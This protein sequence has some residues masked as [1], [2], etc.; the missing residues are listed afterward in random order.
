MNQIAIPQ[1]QPST[2]LEALHIYSSKAGAQYHLRDRRTGKLVTVKR[3]ADHYR[4]LSS[5]FTGVLEDR[6]GYRSGWAVEA[7]S[8]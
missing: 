3:H 7:V 6:L 8:A 4:F 5:A 1:P 2:P